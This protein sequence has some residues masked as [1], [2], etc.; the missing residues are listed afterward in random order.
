MVFNLA[1]F[2]IIDGTNID[3]LLSFGAI[4]LTEDKTQ[5]FVLMSA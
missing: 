2:K 3:V 4:D 5:Q 1:I